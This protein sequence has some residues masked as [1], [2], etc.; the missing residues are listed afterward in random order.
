MSKEAKTE[1]EKLMKDFQEKIDLIIKGLESKVNETRKNEGELLAEVTRK[2]SALESSAVNLNGPPPPINVPDYSKFEKI[3]EQ[4][5][6]RNLPDKIVKNADDKKTETQPHPK[7][8]QILKE[9]K[10]RISPLIKKGD[11][12]SQINSSDLIFL[13]TS[14]KG[15]IKTAVRA[16]PLDKNTVKNQ[17]AFT[18]S[19]RTEIEN[20]LTNAVDRSDIFPAAGS[21][22]FLSNL[23]DSIRQSIDDRLK[24]STESS[25]AIK[26]V[27][28]DLFNK[29]FELGIQGNF[30]SDAAAKEKAAHLFQYSSNL[31]SY[32]EEF[33]KALE[34]THNNSLKAAQAISEANKQYQIFQ[35]K[36]KGLKAK[37]DNVGERNEGG[38]SYA[39]IQTNLKEIDPQQKSIEAGKDNQPGP[40]VIAEVK[41]VT[42]AAET[43]GLKAINATLTSDKD[44]AVQATAEV[45]NNSV[46]EFTASVEKL[47]TNMEDY[48]EHL[49]NYIAAKQKSILTE[50]RKDAGSRANESIKSILKSSPAHNS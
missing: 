45:Y 49:K 36:Y 37:L 30:L 31:L 12:S 41:A 44:E 50:S 40:I 6:K 7:G 19:M 5:V 20:D 46:S 24:T 25:N 10:D 23:K 32:V 2:E 21:M 33:K 39:K 13:E 17:A 9:L 38:S 22:T 16:V 28:S 43:A 47:T 11:N 4:E 26:E 29:I 48:Q 8:V 27:L 35:E 34:E 18:E 14:I 42:L 15:Q 1:S 3:F